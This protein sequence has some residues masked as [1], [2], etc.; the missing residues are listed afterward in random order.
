MRRRFRPRS[1]VLLAAVA[2]AL[3]VAAACADRSEEPGVFEGYYYTGFETSNF[4][5]GRSCD[6]R[7]PRYWLVSDPEARFNEAL[8]EAG[9]EPLAF[10]AFWVRF[11]GE[12]SEPG[13]YGHLGAYEREV[14]VTKLLEL[15][16]APECEG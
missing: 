16:H 11:E 4:V 7:G 14:R 8:R 1:S 6:D 15:R 12:L 3:A 13:R 9:W 2:A 10:Q 5:P